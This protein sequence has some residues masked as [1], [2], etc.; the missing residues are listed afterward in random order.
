MLS[1]PST[2]PFKLREGSEII[3]QDSPEGVC[4]AGGRVSVMSGLG[5]EGGLLS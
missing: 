2:R 1:F 5:K 3:T 4:W